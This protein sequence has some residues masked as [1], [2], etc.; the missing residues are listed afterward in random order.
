MIDAT[1]WHSPLRKNLGNKN[2]ELSESDITRIC[3]AFLSFE[4]SEHSK[5]FP[6]AAF[7]YE[8]VTV[9]RPLRLR[10]DLGA[11]RRGAFRD[12]CSE[13]GEDALADLV[14]AAAER[15]GAG[16]H[17][18]F[19]AFV[20]QLAPLARTAG[21]KLT[22]KR[23]R[24]LQSSLAERDEAASPLL[25][26]VHRAGSV[27]P[28]RL[29]GLFE[30]TMDGVARVVEYEPNSDLRDT[31]QVPLLEDGGIDAFVRREVSPYALDAWF[32]AS[33]VKIGYEVS[34]TR[35]FYKPPPL[36]SLDS[37][38]DDILALEQETDGL[39]AEI[40]GAGAE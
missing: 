26:K 15:L 16:P 7:G 32:D 34:F 33:S 9:E 18:D 10:V 19:G 20:E 31:E 27:E 36:R 23:K 12:A 2:C 5:F 29:H 13:A 22:A 28:D 39:L 6:N 30:V 14:D 38:R 4:E 1:Q 17:D 3:E 21:L 35:H 8:K 24:L 11:A 25:K 40:V 37:I